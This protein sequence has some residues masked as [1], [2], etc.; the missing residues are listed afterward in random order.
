MRTLA[1]IFFYDL[2][3]NQI[4]ADGLMLYEP[5]SGNFKPEYEALLFQ[6]LVNSGLVWTYKLMWQKRGG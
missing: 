5:Y 3:E 6:N 4:I 1:N 2:L